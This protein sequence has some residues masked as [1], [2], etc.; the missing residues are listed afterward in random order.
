[1]NK[2]KLTKEEWCWSL[3]D[4]GNSA[5]IMMLTSII[6]PYIATV[7]QE[8]F[9]LTTAQTSSHWAFTQSIATLLIAI[10]APVLGVLADRKG[11]KKIFFSSFFLLGIT[12]FLAMFFIDNYYLLLAVNI[13]SGIGYAGANVFYDAFLVD[14]TD[15]ER[16]DFISSL[17]YALGYIGS[18]IPFIISILLYSLTPFGLSVIDSIKLGVLINGIW[19][20]AFTLPMFRKV[21]QKYYSEENKNSI[22]YAGK[23]LW[24]TIK[25]ISKNKTIGIFLLAYFFYIDGVDTIIKLSTTYGQSVGLDTTAMIVALLVTQIVAFPAVLVFAKIA[26]RFS[27]KKVLLFCVAVYMGICV[28]GYFLKEEWQFWVLAVV[29]GLVQ[30]TVQAL[31]RS[32][33]GKLIPK[34][35]NNEYFGFYNIFGKYATIIGPLLMGIFTTITGNSRYGVLSIL[36]LFIVGFIL[37]VKVPSIEESK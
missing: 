26:K 24:N 33:F 21:N 20:I 37:L 8:I 16:M 13:L 23:K 7:G 25:L 14:V 15:D 1:M 17:G 19:W 35:N 30:G 29:V 9:G 34:E 4:V 32:Y 27:T 12:M 31:S 3:Y 10:L 36:I 2:L 28:F 6:P 18:C 22:V 5:Y 11:K